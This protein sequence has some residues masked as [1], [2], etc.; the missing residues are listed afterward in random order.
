VIT[1]RSNSEQRDH[2]TYGGSEQRNKVSPT[3]I[4][5][6]FSEE[7]LKSVRNLSCKRINKLIRKE[8]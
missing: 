8:V 2:A 6:V 4:R 3:R 7:A 1:L 5:E